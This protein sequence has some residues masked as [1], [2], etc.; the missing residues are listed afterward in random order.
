MYT[1]HFGLNFKPFNLVPDPKFLYLSP[2]H[3]KALTMLEYG[4]MSQAGFT[5][6][7]GEIGA[8]KTTLV[9]SLLNKLDD[10]YLIGLINNTSESF[11]QLME[12]VLDA[13]EIPSSA[14]D[15][16]GRYRDYVDFVIEQHAKGKKIVLIVDEAQNLSVKAL[17]EL[18]LLSNVNI[19]ADI[20][21]QLVLTGQPELS[22]KLNLPELEQ[23]AQRIG[24]E[25][26]LRALSYPETQKYIEHRMEVAGADHKIFTNEAC[27]AIFCYSEGVP[28]RINN[29]CDFALVYAFADDS[30]EVNVNTVIDMIKDKRSSTIIK[31]K[32]SQNPD[33]KRVRSWLL[34]LYNIHLV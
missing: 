2:V 18:R 34:E 25:Y 8:G 12:W 27:A 5:V 16:A 29:L 33:V 3:K 4:L 23:F 30:K 28:R 26:H 24:V 21:M 11:G 7:T 17:E 19:D 13:L 15:N 20:F 10:E 22:D 32:E 1:E 14:T 31:M 6:V 9:R